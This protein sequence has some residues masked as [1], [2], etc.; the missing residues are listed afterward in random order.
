K[1]CGDRWAYAPTSIGWFLQV[2]WV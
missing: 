1:V 2:V